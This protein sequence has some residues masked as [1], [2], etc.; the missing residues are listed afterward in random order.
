MSWLPGLQMVRRYRREWLR[1]DLLAGVAVT[2][3]MIPHGMAYA[4]LA[5]VP[6]VTG[7]YTTITSVLAYALFGPSR[8]LLLGP[9]SSLAPLIAAAIAIAASDGEPA[10]AIAIA[11]M[12]ALMTGGLCVL[13]GISRL[14]SIAELLSRPVQLG[15]LN[16]LAI[17]MV[18][19]QTSKLA[20]FSVSGD[21]PV[22]QTWDVVTGVADGLVNVRA[23][24]IGAAALISILVLN[25]VASSIPA[26]LIVVVGATVTVRLFGLADDGVAIVGELPSGFPSPVWPSIELATVP[27]LLLA[28]VGLAW[29]TLSDTTA[30]SRGFAARTGERVDPNREI[31]A[32]GISNVAAGAFSGFP[33]SASTSRTTIAHASGG[34]TQLVGVVSAVLVLVLLMAGGGLVEFLPSTALAAIVIAAAIKLFDAHQV[35]WLYTVRRS[36]FALCIAATVGVVLL[37]VLNGLAIA[38]GLSLANFIR[39]VWRP[40]DAVLGRIDQRKGYHDLGRHPDARQVPGLV[41]FR[42][43]APL[44]FANSDHFERRVR[45]VIASSPHRVRRLVVAAE[46]ITDIDTSAAAMLA[47]LIDDLQ[48][49]DIELAFAELKG[50]VKDRLI[51]YGLYDQ[52]GSTRFHSTIGVAVKSY[53]RSHQV[54]WANWDD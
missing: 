2:A 36:E 14:G 15:Y 30:L 7:L 40:Y 43:D 50:P 11:G 5:G 47:I 24:L 18:L 34:N 45:A 10:T 19:S 38:I 48:R 1:G 37:G 42:F 25:R 31:V 39:R 54:E 46:P 33:V 20:G 32:L 29:V 27:S 13:A 16:G 53:I 49:N 22:E 4:E 28:S 9:D 23:L 17:V 52:I 44:F 12:L 3:L 51:Q 35:S 6:A 26:V 41:L 8:V 21:T